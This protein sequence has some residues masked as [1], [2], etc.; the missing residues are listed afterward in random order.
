M[1]S[2]RLSRP[3]S[4]DDHHRGRLAATSQLV[5]YGDYECPYTRRALI[6]IRSVREQLG[7]DF[8]LIFRNFPLVDIHPHALHAAQAAEAADQLG[9]FWEMHDQLFDNQRALTDDDLRGYAR[10]LGM[11]EEA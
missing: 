1:P 3:V 2:K 10:G 11:D 6:Q 4:E 9:K 5:V 7:D 8:V